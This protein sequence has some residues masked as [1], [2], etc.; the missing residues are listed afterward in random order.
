LVQWRRIAAD[1][2]ESFPLGTD[3]SGTLLYTDDGYMS[4][5]MVAAERPGIEGGDPLGGDPEARAAAYSTCLAYAGTWERDGDVVT[6]WVTDS[7]YPNWSATVQP[8]SIAD[9]DGQLVLRTPQDGPGAVV[10][11]IA[12][13]RPAVL[14]H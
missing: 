1:G 13:T 10:N 5:M 3:A 4:A 11:E 7:L 2:T 8:R 14:T 12:W 9:R 6:H